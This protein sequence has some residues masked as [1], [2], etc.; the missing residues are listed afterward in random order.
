M[1][2]LKYIVAK[3]KILRK[4]AITLIKTYRSFVYNILFSILPVK[5]KMVL[6]CSHKGQGFSCNPKALYNEM[7]DNDQ[8]KDFVFVW[9]FN[10]VKDNHIDGA[11]NVKYNSL[12]YFYYLATCKYWFFNAKMPVYYKKKKNQVYLQ[13]WHGTP[14][15]RLAADI[16]VGDS[17]TFYRSEMSWDDM[18]TSYVKDS[19]KYDYMIAANP[20]SSGAFSSAF[21][22]KPR[23]IIDTGYPRNDILINAS[24]EY[25]EE[26]KEKYNIPKNKK[27]ILY[28]PTWRDNTYDTRGY[29][30]E[31]KVDFNAWY[32][33]LGH[34]YV[35]LYK[36]HYLIYNTVSKG[37]PENFIYDASHC[38]DINDL[39]LISDILITDYS[40]VFFDYGVLKRP[41]LFYMYDLQEYRDHLRGFYLDIYEEL[42]GPILER[43]E[44]LLDRLVHI[45]ELQEEYKERMNRFYQDYCQWNDGESSKKVLDIV[46]RQDK[47]G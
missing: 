1:N 18:V 21:R 41:V 42:P 13:T 8:Y 47:R 35:V 6:F 11:I 7:K 43:E 34:E 9:A 12:A 40:S 15:K 28:A 16:E 14:L 10:N 32:K 22:L 2:R 19:E 17:T 29:V 20:F 30:F 3:N 38:Q 24:R 4:I 44:D 46:F 37:L 39:Y 45:E 36:P 26:L 5:D 25:V 33:A 27:V 31:L 23:V